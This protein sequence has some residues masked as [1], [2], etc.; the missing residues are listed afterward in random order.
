[1]EFPPHAGPVPPDGNHPPDA[2]AEAPELEAADFVPTGR[3]F[4]AAGI[5]IAPIEGDNLAPYESLPLA[6]YPGLARLRGQPSF[7]PQGSPRNFPYPTVRGPNGKPMREFGVHTWFINTASLKRCRDALNLPPLLM[8]DNLTGFSDAVDQLLS[9]E[10]NCG[11]GF[12]RASQSTIDDYCGELR[13]CERF[14]IILGLPRD[15]TQSPMTITEILCWLSYKYVSPF[16]PNVEMLTNLIQGI[17]SAAGMDPNEFD[18]DDQPRSHSW[19]KDWPLRFGWPLGCHSSNFNR[20]IWAL[21]LSHFVCGHSGPYSER[22]VDGVVVASGS[23]FFDSRCQARIEAFRKYVKSY[24]HESH[25]TL[26]FDILL[27]MP[28]VHKSQ[29]NDDPGRLLERINN[30]TLLKIRIPTRMRRVESTNILSN[31]IHFL[32]L[33]GTDNT[34]SVDEYGIPRAT[35]ITIMKQKGVTSGGAAE[36]TLVP[37]PDPLLCG[38]RQLIYNLLM[39]DQQLGRIP[40]FIFYRVDGAGAPI[41]RPYATLREDSAFE[42]RRWRNVMID[43]GLVIEVPAVQGRAARTVIKYTTHSPCVAFMLNASLC[44]IDFDVAKIAGRWASDSSANQISMYLATNPGQVHP[45]TTRYPW[46]NT[47]PRQVQSAELNSVHV[48]N[49]QRNRQVGLRAVAGRNMTNEQFNEG[50]LLGWVPSLSITEAL[51]IFKQMWPNPIDVFSKPG[52]SSGGEYLTD[53]ERAQFCARTRPPIPASTHDKLAP[54]LSLK[55]ANIKSMFD[56]FHT[57]TPAT[58]SVKRWK[59]LAAGFTTSE[60]KN[61]NS[62]KRLVDCFEAKFE[63]NEKGWNRFFSSTFRQ[64]DWIC[65]TAKNGKLKPELLKDRLLEAMVYEDSDE[66]LPISMSTILTVIKC[67]TLQ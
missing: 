55:S 25:R 12:S 34:I 54:S 37:K 57:G 41:D 53:D 2:P 42:S 24:N 3:F 35:T 20:S 1:M 28:K 27:D 9:M 31:E 8:T 7:S 33:F 56:M 14:W 60:A 19:R 26:A 13:Q 22:V 17:R 21:R 39:V 36:V 59:D 44:K 38:T 62:F 23:P 65:T 29:F 67:F 52:E 32:C 45:M 43:S 64:D 49:G 40:K 66:S 6:Q 58:E 11:A 50:S 10:M 46:N 15:L 30:V 16:D 48:S 47:H 4:D 51:P 18:I 63:C 61:F 5:A